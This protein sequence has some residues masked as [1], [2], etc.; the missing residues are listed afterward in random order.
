M[1]TIKYDTSSMMYHLDDGA[2]ITKHESREEAEFHYVHRFIDHTVKNF[3][4]YHC[5]YANDGVTIVEITLAM[6]MCINFFKD[7]AKNDAIFKKDGYAVHGVTQDE[8]R[9]YF[10]KYIK[11]LPENDEM[12]HCSAM[13]SDVE[14][15]SY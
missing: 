8:I 15:L 4:D 14:I 5:K 11:R 3:T 10:A 6:Q 1:A 2:T 9:K 12:F 7:K 13:L